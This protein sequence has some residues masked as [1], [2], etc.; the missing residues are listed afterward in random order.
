MAD[1]RLPSGQTEGSTHEV[2]QW[3]KQVG[4]SVRKDEPL[5]EIITDKV[6]V[7]IAA[8][9]DGVLEEILKQTGEAI[10]PADVLGRIGARAPAAS[11]QDGRTAG[12]PDGKTAAGPG[13]P[14]TSLPSGPPAVLPSDLSPAV[15]RLIQ[16]HGL[17]PAQIKGT[18]S[19]GRITAQDVEVYL[20]ALPSG[21]PAVLPSSR[22]VPHSSLR[23]NI[24][25]HMVRS[26][27]TAPHVTALFEADLSRVVA[28]RSRFGDKK[29]T[30]TAYFVRAAVAA[31]QAVPETNSRW[32]DDALEILEDY[33][34]GVAVALPGGGLIVPV[35]HQAQNLSLEATAQRLEDLTA[36]A[37]SGKLTP[38]EV[39]GG[40]FSISNHGVSGSLLAAPIVIVQPQSAIL[41]IGKLEQR[42]RVM[43]SGGIEARPML[44]VT[45]TIDHRVL[46]G[47]QANQFLS[48]W[49]ETIE[50]WSD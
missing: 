32:H 40:T 6:T 1:I 25:E 26:M 5:L 7:E 21:R 2:G 12:R 38:K 45:L 16:Q 20:A 11:R 47:F 35:L 30:Y 33:N 41:G 42:P 9:A 46:D 22:R 34:I 23:R 24:A 37:R 48:R 17:D 13:D 10:T 49:I 28:H 14:A 43:P 50:G 19:G 44:Y 4:D 29:P 31:L 36:R 27:Q 18:G 39:Q 15:R 3:L 8:P